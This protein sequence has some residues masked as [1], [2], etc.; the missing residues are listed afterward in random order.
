MAIKIIANYSKRLGLPGYSSHQASIS[1]ESE[2]TDLGQ[3]QGEVT[4]LYGL[5]QDSVDRELQNTGFVP[6]ETYGMDRPANNGNGA[7]GNGA[8]HAPTRANGNDNSNCA[9][10]CS[11]K[12]RGLIEKLSKQR[13]LVLDEVDATAHDRFGVGVAELNKLQ[14]SGLIQ[15]LLETTA[16]S[17][18]NGRKGGG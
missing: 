4:R 16:S 8:H 10:S 15:E 14:A 9:W 2:L 18:G 12:Q 6:L 11:D 3:V 13:N 1:V 7:N 17:N 5:L